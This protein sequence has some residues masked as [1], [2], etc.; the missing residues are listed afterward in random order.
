M[1]MRVSDKGPAFSVRLT[2]T[3]PFGRSTVV[4][5]FAALA[6]G[7]IVRMIVLSACARA[8]RPLPATSARAATTMPFDLN[9]NVTSRGA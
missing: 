4:L 1:T 5:H 9:G 3:T 2:V 7:G 8:C 6:G